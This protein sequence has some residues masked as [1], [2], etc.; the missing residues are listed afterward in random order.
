VRVIDSVDA[1]AVYLDGLIN[2][3]REPKSGP[4]VDLEPVR[5]LLAAVG[6]P[7]R[8]LSVLHVAGSKGKGST[9]LLAEAVLLALGE[10][11]GTFTSP[12]LTRWTE[13]FRIDGAEVSGAK[14][15][16][17]V[18]RLRPVVESL[19]ADSQAAS[20]SFFDATTA[21]A[22]L[23][24]AEAGV[25]RVAL[26]VGLGGRLDSTNVV[27]PAV[28]AVTSIELEHTDLLGDTIVKIAGEK[29]GIL[30]PGVPCV[31]GR[32]SADAARVV[33]ER[34]SELGAP[35][36]RLGSEFDVELLAQSGA[37]LSMRYHDREGFELETTLP[38]L[39][40]H[41]ADNAAVALAALR[42]LAAHD[43]QQLA[44][45][46][47]R[48]LAKVRLAGRVEIVER[49]PCV[50]ID[51]AH[52]EASARALAAALE[53][54]PRSRAEFVLSISAGKDMQSILRLLLPL[55]SRVSLTRAEPH[56]SA[57]PAEIAAA[58]RQIDPAVELEL[59]AD[60]RQAIC[61]ARERVQRG[62]LLCITGSVYLAGIAREILCPGG[63]HGG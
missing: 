57:D 35:L 10:R 12:H 13:R 5:R 28:T 9:C 21:A 1:A 29:A 36:H 24:F 42:Q 41:H 6:D 20:P 7:Q 16:A 53:G 15:A 46:A 26:E 32:L 58:A 17:A 27:T 8:E 19:R 38:L 52:T 44:A 59:V 34:A 51:S 3:E 60:P 25:D 2:R 11:V 43:P 39:G 22:L 55:A 30:K 45:A 40:A 54:L 47:E 18:E 14:L 56:R 62:E 48:G 31:T 23:L 37:G 61:A 50:V 49:D 4:R 33:E 63:A